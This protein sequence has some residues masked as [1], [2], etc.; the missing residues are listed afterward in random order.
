MNEH[1]T[2]T[3]IERYRE[4][5]LPPAELLDADDH[6]AGCEICRQRLDDEQRL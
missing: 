2:E 5:A 6:L 3:L 1:L 4:Q